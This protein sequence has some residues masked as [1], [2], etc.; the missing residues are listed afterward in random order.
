MLR[1]ALQALYLPEGTEIL[2]E[3]D[4]CPQNR[5]STSAS[6][7]HN[8]LTRA[9][10]AGYFGAKIWITRTS[11][12]EPGSGTAYRQIFAKYSGF[13]RTLC[14][15]GLKEDG[16]LVPLAS[17]PLFNFPPETKQYY[18]TGNWL[19]R[20]AVMGFPFH[21]N[22][23]VWRNSSAAALSGDD[24]DAL[25]DA[26]IEKLFDLDL[27]LDGSAALKLSR[28]GFAARLGV[29]AEA[30][31][32]LPAPSFESEKDSP[33]QIALAV[34]NEPVRL[35]VNP[36]VRGETL[37]WI[38]HQTSRVSDDAA[39]VAPGSIRVTRP[40][41]H[42]LF[43][44]AVSLTP[45]GFAMFAFLN[46][47]RKAQFAELFKDY[48]S[49]YYRGDAE[50]MMQSGRDCEGNRIAVIHSMSPD[51]L[52][53]P[54]LVFRDEVRSIERLM[55]DGSW[56]SLS[57]DKDGKCIRPELSVKMLYPEVLRVR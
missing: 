22:K 55:P 24:C 3:P 51:E 54:C 9:L 57:F 20:T 50:V 17:Q 36:D 48:A 7:L 37:T 2:D 16:I 40:D 29:S 41:G 27:I 49:V 6:L 8:H 44:T 12:F 43:V 15:L 35:T 39:I 32:D 31:G 34:R 14:N 33:V 13:Y 18:T 42:S 26:D 56:R 21:L 46:E 25:P 52:E 53:N 11:T 45:Y 30:W 10:I 4:T 38:S 5:Y 47:T 28:R 1:S 19:T 23:A